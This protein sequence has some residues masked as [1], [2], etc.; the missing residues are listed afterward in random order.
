MKYEILGN[1]L[2]VYYDECTKLEYDMCNLKDK[3]DNIPVDYMSS[4]ERT[5]LIHELEEV[6][7]LPKHL[8]DDMG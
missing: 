6:G 2:F 8:R 7:I 4:T 3:I 5:E 1:R